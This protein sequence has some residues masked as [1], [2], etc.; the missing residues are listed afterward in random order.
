MKYYNLIRNNQKF[1]PYSLDVLKQY[2]ENGSILLAD[3]IE[4]VGNRDT[5]VKNVLKQNNIKF[6][7]QSKGNI[8]EQI[9]KIGKELII[10]KSDFIKKDILKDR[11]LLYLSI[12]GLSPAFLIKFSFNNWLTFYLIALYFSTLWGVFFFYI[13]RTNQVRTKQTISLFFLT[14]LAALIL[15]NVQ[16]LPIISSLYDLTESKNFIGQFI[17][18][19]LGVGIVEET[20]KAIPLFYILKKTE[21]PLIP[22]TMVYYGLMSGIGFGV[23]EGVLYQ[24][25]TNKELAY[26]EA[27]FMN[28]A[29]LTSLPFL[30]AI[31]A[32][33]AGYFLSFSFLYPL[34][35]KGLWVLSIL[36][37]ALLHGFYDTFGWSIIGLSST[38]LSVILLMF[39]IKRSSDYQ[40][41]LISIT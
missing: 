33:I 7:I 22:Q 30:H 39:Y 41:K 24:T 35:R 12:L 15:V 6:V 20:I 34:Y 13:F 14:Q 17:G 8:I 2:V 3:V 4:S 28:I 11:R 18:Y 26:N 37:P 40:S 16:S 1:G 10:P 27:F 31:W 5:T 38:I 32:A 36:I 29:R 21:S 25:T 23:L 9:K 19:T